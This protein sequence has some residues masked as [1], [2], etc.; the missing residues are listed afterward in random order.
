[1]VYATACEVGCALAECPYL[2]PK[3]VAYFQSFAMDKNGLDVE[4]PDTFL[5]VCNY[6]PGLSENNIYKLRPYYQGRPC[7]R[8]PEE[9]SSCDDGAVGGQ[10]GPRPDSGLCCEWL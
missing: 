3:D 2:P 1:M 9:Y 5:V 8:C 10:Q 4:N 6:G 7:S